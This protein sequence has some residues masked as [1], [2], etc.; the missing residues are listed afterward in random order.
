MEYPLE[1]RNQ[2][3]FSTIRKQVIKN[4]STNMLNI[5]IGVKYNFF[6]DRIQYK[7]SNWLACDNGSATFVLYGLPLLIARPEH[8]T[9]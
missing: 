8:H 4:T 7:N 3:N 1:V 2:P 6:Q 5:F 9:Q